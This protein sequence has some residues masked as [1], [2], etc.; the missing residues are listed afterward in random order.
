MSV[1]EN[2]T[3]WMSWNHLP[4]KNGLRSLKGHVWYQRWTVIRGCCQLG[5]RKVTLLDWL[6]YILAWCNNSL[7]RTC[8]QLNSIFVFQCSTVGKYFDQTSWMLCLCSFGNYKTCLLIGCLHRN[9]K[10]CV[11]FHEESHLD[12][13]IHLELYGVGISVFFFSITLLFKTID[14]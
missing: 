10:S 1:L 3:I 13:I 9:V 5:V 4:L 11:C 12:L 2:H 14:N 6:L 8:G 7:P